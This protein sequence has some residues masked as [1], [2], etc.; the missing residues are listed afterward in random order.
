[1][2]SRDEIKKVIVTDMFKIINIYTKN[3][4]QA[5]KFLEIHT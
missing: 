5:W 2:I 1:M 3:V 4:M